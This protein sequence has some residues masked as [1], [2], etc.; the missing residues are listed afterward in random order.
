MRICL[1]VLL[2]SGR[3]GLDPNAVQAA[4]KL[5][6]PGDSIDQGPACAMCFNGSQTVPA[7]MGCCC[8]LP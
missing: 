8:D 5:A 1:V 4:F 6:N 7:G 2:V 3:P